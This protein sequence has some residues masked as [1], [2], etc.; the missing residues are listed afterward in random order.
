MS[1]RKPAGVSCMCIADRVAGV[2]QQVL[3]QVR[4]QARSRFGSS[5]SASGFAGAWDL[6]LLVM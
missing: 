6:P 1:T 5:E 3:V 4:V 2:H